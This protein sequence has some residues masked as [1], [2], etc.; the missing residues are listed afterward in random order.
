MEGATEDLSTEELEGC[1]RAGRN[2]YDILLHS[3][4]PSLLDIGA[5]DLTFEQELVDQYVP[6]LRS[7]NKMLR[8]H[9]FD[10]LTP[11]SRVGG[12][13]HKNRDRERH[14]KSFPSEELKYQFWGGM[15]LEQFGQAKD[16]LPRY[17]MCT[18][19]APANPYVCL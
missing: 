13:Y 11:G 8:L 4:S 16:A 3:Q 6:Q 19:H 1:L 2:P 10:R 17:T 18:C 7:Q 12:V 14:L 5:G 15:D 9:A